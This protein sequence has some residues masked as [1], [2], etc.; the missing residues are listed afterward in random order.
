MLFNELPQMR[1]GKQGL[2]LS[3]N[4]LLIQGELG[5]S[6]GAIV[7]PQAQAYQSRRALQVLVGNIL[8]CSSNPRAR[9]CSSSS[10]YPQRLDRIRSTQHETDIVTH[11]LNSMRRMRGGRRSLWLRHGLAASP[12]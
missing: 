9:G 6:E 3:I 12:S 11:L 8:K 2:E 7:G 1:H 10:V 4:L 5:W